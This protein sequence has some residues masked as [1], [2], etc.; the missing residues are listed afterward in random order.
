VYVCVIVCVC[1]YVYECLCE[2]VWHVRVHVHESINTSM[3]AN[4]SKDNKE[5]LHYL[6]FP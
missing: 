1:V 4:C 6:L 3:D 2:W 5:Q